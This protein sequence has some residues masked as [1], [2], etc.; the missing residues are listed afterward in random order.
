ME[1]RE[2]GSLSFIAGVSRDA[3]YRVCTAVSR[4]VRYAAPAATGHV[5]TGV[6]N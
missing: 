5:R 6:R 3:I 1:N 2:W 4:D